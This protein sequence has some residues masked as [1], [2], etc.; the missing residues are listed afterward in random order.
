MAPDA[1]N[2]AEL[3]TQIEMG[4]L[5]A[6]TVG[7]VLTTKEIVLVPGQVNVFVPV[8]VY[9]VVDVGETTTLL[10]VKAPGFQV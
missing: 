6:L 1:D 10:P 3:P 9:I 5:L 4:L 2:V 8:M 7:V